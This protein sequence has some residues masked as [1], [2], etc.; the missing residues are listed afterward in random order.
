MEND[1]GLMWIGFPTGECSMEKMMGDEH[2]WMKNHNPIVENFRWDMMR[3][4]SV[5]EEP[6]PWFITHKIHQII[7][8]LVGYILSIFLL[9]YIPIIVHYQNYTSSLNIS[10]WC[11]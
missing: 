5:D 9:Q 7:L 3:D 4:E 8:L 2:M 6:D 10:H 1:E 11:G